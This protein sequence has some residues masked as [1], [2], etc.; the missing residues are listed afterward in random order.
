VQRLREFRERQGELSREA[1]Q[2]LIK[3]RQVSR[4]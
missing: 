2:L 1:D 3:L 4:N